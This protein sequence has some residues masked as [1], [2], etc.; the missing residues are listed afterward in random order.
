MRTPGTGLLT[1]PEEMP[2][3]QD[4]TR[5]EEKPKTRVMTE[6]KEIIGIEEPV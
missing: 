4:M 5:T 2:E 3:T 6:S 1:E